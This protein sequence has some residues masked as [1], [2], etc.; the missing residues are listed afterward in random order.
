MAGGL[1]DAL[2][3]GW[4]EGDWRAGEQQAGGRAKGG[5][6][7]GWPEN[8]QTAPARRACGIPW[9]IFDRGH[10]LAE[11]NMNNHIK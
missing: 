11:N 7:L 3:R 6:A 9:L 2:E 4:P 5:R 1:A 10:S 8:P